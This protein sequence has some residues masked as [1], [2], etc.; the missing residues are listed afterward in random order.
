MLEHLGH[1]DSVKAVV[2]KRIGMLLEIP[3]HELDALPLEVRF[4]GPFS[5]SLP[6]IGGDPDV[7]GGYVI[8]GSRQSKRLL[9]RRGAEL[10]RPGRWREV[11]LQMVED[12]GVPLTGS[13]D[14]PL[15]HK[16][17]PSVSASGSRAGLAPAHS[18][19]TL[20]P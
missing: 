10:N 17:D 6:G 5:S 2:R 7:D 19:G 20:D 12:E 18:A 3:L 1:Y 14:V 11:A 13:A 16:R 15:I 4:H 9:A 8:A